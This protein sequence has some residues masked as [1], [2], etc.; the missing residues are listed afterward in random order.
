MVINCTLKIYFNDF[1]FFC[2]SRVFI[3][4]NAWGHVVCKMLG[5]KALIDISPG[6][7]LAD[8]YNYLYTKSVRII[9][10]KNIKHK[11]GFHLNFDVAINC[12][13]KWF[14]FYLWKRGHGNSYEKWSSVP[15]KNSNAKYGSFWYMSLKMIFIKTLGRIS[16]NVD[17]TSPVK[18][19]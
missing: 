14:I 18:G 10:F 8:T 9:I 15:Y 4:E 3:Q 2:N 12:M 5:L 1:F 11:R 7:L 17:T 19:E 16:S 13:F 6:F